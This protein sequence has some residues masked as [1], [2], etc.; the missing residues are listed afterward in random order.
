MTKRGS[1]SCCQEHFSLK[2][3]YFLVFHHPVDAIKIIIFYIKKKAHRKRH[4]FSFCYL[5]RKQH[6]EFEEINDSG[7]ISAEGKHSQTDKNDK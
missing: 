7:Y 5:V 6:L 4:V 1:E 3:L 2:R